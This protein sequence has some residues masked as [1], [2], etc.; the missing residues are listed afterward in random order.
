MNALGTDVLKAMESSSLGRMSIY[1]LS[2]QTSDLGIDLD[3]LSHDDLP[4]LTSRLKAVLPFFL[5]S[6]TDEV[7]NKIRKISNNTVVST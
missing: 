6:E 1:V 2:K 3:N 5:A 7:L 4:K